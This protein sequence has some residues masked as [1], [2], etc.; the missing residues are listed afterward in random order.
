MKEWR[1]V[2]GFQNYQISIDTPEGI[3]RSL[4]LYAHK[5][6]IFLSNKPSIRD[7]RINWVL[8]KGGKSIC[9]QA[10]KWIAI[11]YPE[12]VQNEWFPG[13]YIDHIDTNKLNNHPSNLRWVTVKENNNNPLSKKH[14]SES[15]KGR[16]FSD[17]KRKKL[18]ITNKNNS[19]T[20]KPVKQY[21]KSG[22]LVA[23]YPSINEAYRVT[24]IG[25][26]AISRCCRKYPKY[27]TAGGYV[28]T[29]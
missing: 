9:K 8:R 1:S 16:T 12:L 5:A 11:T 21:T 3:C 19:Y 10:A 4:N 13:A 6:P 24:K 7:G 26:S 25:A 2:P 14:K 22:V 20:S 15:L 28:W 27:K 18:S 29:Y 17:I 23:L